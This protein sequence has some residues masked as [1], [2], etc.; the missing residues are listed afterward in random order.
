MIIWDYHDPWASQFFNGRH[1]GFWTL[2]TVNILLQHVSFN[3]SVVDGVYGFTM[4]VVW[5][6][7]FGFYYPIHLR[8]IFGSCANDCE[9]VWTPA[10]S[11]CLNHPCHLLI[12]TVEK[13][14]LSAAGESAAFPGIQ[15]SAI[16][17]DLRSLKWLVVWLPWILFS[18]KYW[19]SNHHPNWRSPIF[20][21][22][23]RVAD[24]SPATL[25]DLAP[26]SRI[27]HFQPPKNISRW[28]KNDMVP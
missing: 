20:Q 25:N 18:Q 12:R 15:K 24:S 4:V 26:G 13:N 27:A 5:W 3:T 19:E 8:G 7:M 21:R 23:G 10:G 6:L 17:L 9:H 1:F 14:H 28:L 16:C 11:I 2:L 22:G